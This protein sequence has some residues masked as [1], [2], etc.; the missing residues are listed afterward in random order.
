MIQTR[1]NRSTPIP[2]TLEKRGTGLYP[3]VK[4]YDIS[5]N[6]I[7]TVNL[8]EIGGGEY[9]GTYTPDG[10][11]SSLELRCEIYTDS[12]HSVISTT[13]G[14][15]ETEIMIV[16]DSSTLTAAQVNAE[17]DTAISDAA[18]ATS[19]E[20]ADVQTH[21]DSEWSTADVSALATSA[22]QSQILKALINTKFLDDVNYKIIIYDDDGTTPL[23]EF[24]T[25]NA[26]GELATESIKKFEKI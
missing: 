9:K 11:L 25:K 5:N 7:E 2:L 10:T 20:L 15:P 14:K 18:L 12:G 13:H 3:Q 24:Y 8:L 21:G 19:A 22:V 17:C 1:A 6:L 23:F 4:I 16:D 26:D